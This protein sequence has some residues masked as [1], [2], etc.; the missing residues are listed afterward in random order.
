MLQKSPFLLCL[1]QAAHSRFSPTVGWHSLQ[2]KA[3]AV[4]VTSRISTRTHLVI[5][6][7]AGKTQQKERGM[8]KSVVPSFTTLFQLHLYWPSVG[9]LVPR[10]ATVNDFFEFFVKSE[11][12]SKFVA[13]GELGQRR[14]PCHRV[15]RDPAGMR[16]GPAMCSVSVKAPT[17]ANIGWALQIASGEYTSIYNFQTGDTWGR[18]QH[19]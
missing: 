7:T 9:I 16:T 4:P 10:C 1:T 19:P 5:P 13:E 14:A 3:K 8:S 18:F 15:G 6:N 17:D 11:I 12:H 2:I